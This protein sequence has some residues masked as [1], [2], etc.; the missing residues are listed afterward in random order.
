MLSHNILKYMGFVKSRFGDYAYFTFAGDRAL[1]R[2]VSQNHSLRKV[3]QKRRFSVMGNPLPDPT[4]IVF[5]HGVG[6]GIL[7]YLDFVCS[8]VCTGHPVVIVEYRHVA[9]RLCWKIPSCSEVADNVMTILDRVGV[10]KASFVSHSYGTFVLSRILKTNKKRVQSACFIDPV[11]IG[12]YRS[13]KRMT[14]D[15]RQVPEHTDWLPKS[16][17]CASQIVY[18]AASTSDTEYWH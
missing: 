8:L 11:C 16:T 5:L 17:D 13:E 7:P 9:M 12:E 10:A 15:F 3:N 1:A 4:P 14:P 18:W 2:K 6:L